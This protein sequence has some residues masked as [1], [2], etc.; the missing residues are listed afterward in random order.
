MTSI[1]GP[2]ASASGKLL[3]SPALP[4][5]SFYTSAGLSTK[6]GAKM[7]SEP[8]F[9]YLVDYYGSGNYAHRWVEAAFAGSAIGFDNGDANFSLYGILG[10]LQGIKK[11]TAYMHVL[12]YAIHEM[13]SAVG[14]CE[15]GS[16]D[17]NAAALHAWDEGVVSSR[18]R[19][20]ICRTGRS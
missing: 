20:V 8:H 7:T 19:T 12:M 1:A 18:C 3:T 2:M 4:F 17:G 10:R 11:G 5:S 15:A 6:A 16:A 14:K 13:E 9:T